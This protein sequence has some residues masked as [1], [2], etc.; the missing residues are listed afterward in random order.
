MMAFIVFILSLIF[1]ALLYDHYRGIDNKLKEA[2]TE[3]NDLQETKT[4]LV[5][6]INFLQKKVSDSFTDPVTQLP[7]WQL[8]E[9]RI[10]QHIRESER[11]R[12]TMGLM[13]IDIDNFKVINEALGPEVGNVLLREV[14]LRI[15]ECI[16]QVDSMSRF[17][18]DTFVVLLLQLS[19]PETAAIVGQRIL[20]A[21]LEPF[22]INDQE[23][24][25][26]VC[27]GIALYPHDAKNTE[28][29]LQNAGYALQLAKKTGTNICQFYEEKMHIQSQH[30]LILYNAV[31]RESIYQEFSIFYQPI[32]NTK[33]NTLLCLDTML[34]WQHPELGI[35]S[36]EELYESAE[37]QR[38]L[39]AFSSWLL[40][41][42]CKQ[43][44]EWRAKGSKPDLLAI[45]LSIKQ[46]ESGN[47]VYQLSNILQ[48]TGFNPQW[49]L[50]EIKEH[51]LN[52]SLEIL[53]KA[54]NMLNY[55]GIKIA[56]DHFGSGSLTLRYF[57]KISMHYLK[58]D[59]LFID[60][61][62]ENKTTQALV[63]SIMYL[64]QAMDIQVIVNGV[65][66]ELQMKMLKQ[67]GC[68]FVQGSFVSAPLT[69]DDLARR[70][71]ALSE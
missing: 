13:F 39:N 50:I 29:L 66:N 54:F 15:A 53:E 38:K 59:R 40:Q 27:I 42:A 2:T 46:L 20:R 35:I 36:S 60:D 17:A 34:E 45:P 22:Q 23:L 37:R 19:K 9:D 28:S 8:F 30:D 10:T 71:A 1:I 69:G 63:K 21:F 61:I 31:N 7:G 65:E 47:F 24:Y 70:F 14:A 16:R 62:V 58:L 33:D 32:I 26:T 43:F 4:R 68:Q 18:K 5:E 25:V 3:M 56:I 52:V 57:K 64:A 41:N 11:Y 12:F 55:L 48:S 49:L 67:L 6:K 51:F 44:L